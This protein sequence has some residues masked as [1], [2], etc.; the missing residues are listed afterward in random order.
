VAATALHAAESTPTDSHLTL[1]DSIDLLRNIVH[2][3]DLFADARER[4]RVDHFSDLELPVA[5]LWQTLLDQHQLGTLS[6][7]SLLADYRSRVAPCPE[8]VPREALDELLVAIREAYDRPADDFSEAYGRDLL[9]RFVIEREVWDPLQQTIAAAD[10]LHR[11]PHDLATILQT[12]ADRLAALARPNERFRVYSPEEFEQAHFEHEWLLDGFLLKG[13]P[14]M[15]AGPAKS[16]KTSLVAEMAVCMG[17]GTTRL[18]NHFQIAQPRR[19]VGFI[20]G[21]SGEATVQD[22]LRRICASKGRTIGSSN[23]WVCFRIPTVQTEL[24]ALTAMIRANHWDVVILDPLYL[25]LLAGEHDAD[26]ASKLTTMGPLL[27]TLCK[28]CLGL[29]CTPVLV[30][31][32]TKYLGGRRGAERFEPMELT[33][34]HGAGTSEYMR[35]WALVSRREPFEDGSSVERVWLRVGGSGFEAR[36]WALDVDQGRFCPA[37][38]TRER[39]HITV[40]TAEQARDQATRRRDQRHDARSVAADMDAELRLLEAMRRHPEGEMETTLKRSAAIGKNRNVLHIL[41]RLVAEH[42][43]ERSEKV[44]QVGSCRRPVLVYRLVHGGRNL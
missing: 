3:P 16:L 7:D 6:R 24:G 27:D 8:D 25:S 20:S 33:D 5:A 14:A 12:Y 44:R 36:L 39:W 41:D 1:W 9:R 15:V 37:T 42:R 18:F 31:H 19:R 28:T 22:T 34:I 13:Q 30:H 17:L 43:V 40:H 11:V 10:R 32:S 23:V 21:E 26:A 35:Q 38:V 2:F 29:G 4:L